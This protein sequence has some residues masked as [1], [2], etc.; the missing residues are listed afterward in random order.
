MRN[1]RRFLCMAAFVTVGAVLWLAP[2]GLALR[3]AVVKQVFSGK[4]VRLEVIEKKPVGGSTDWRIDHGVITAL[5]STQ[6]TVREADGRIQ[7]IP[8]SS[9]T[10]VVRRGHLSSQDRLRP[11]LNVLVT[12]RADGAAQNV[13]IDPV[14]AWLRRAIVKQLFGPKLVRLEAIEKKPVAGSTD[15][16]VDRGVITAVSS[17][18]LTV[19][20]ADGRIQ[21]IPVSTSTLVFR[22]GRILSPDVL[23]AGW[24][25]AVTWPAS[26]AAQAVDVE[27]LRPRF[28]GRG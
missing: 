9:S 20:E 14:P 8:L 4:L 28:P 26:G 10:R 5:N 23:A 13:I 21:L 27:S 19:R 12:W 18:Q 22:H 2:A 25:V 3:N 1:R 7:V 17:T 15:W 11:H 24:H 16:R 6:L